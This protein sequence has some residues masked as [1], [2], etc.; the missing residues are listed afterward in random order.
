[1]RPIG[2]AASIRPKTA[3]QKVPVKKEPLVIYPFECKLRAKRVDDNPKILEQIIAHKHR[4][5]SK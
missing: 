4:N 2:S 1:L 5:T 3:I